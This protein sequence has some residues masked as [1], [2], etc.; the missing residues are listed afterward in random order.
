MKCPELRHELPCGWNQF[1]TF[2]VTSL[3]PKLLTWYWGRWRRFLST[4][5]PVPHKTMLAAARDWG[6]SILTQE[7]T[8]SVAWAEYVFE[9]YKDSPA[10]VLSF[11]LHGF[12]KTKTD[13]HAALNPTMQLFWWRKRLSKTW[14][15]L[16]TL[17]LCFLFTPQCYVQPRPIT[18]HV[19]EHEKWIAFQVLPLVKEKSSVSPK[20]NSFFREPTWA[21][22]PPWVSEPA[23]VVRSTYSLAPSLTGNPLFAGY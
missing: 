15:P 19:T 16:Q 5:D 11:K 12:E 9:D 21:N 14:I 20:E 4:G 3:F 8:R 1:A 23:L 17:P 22:P 6:E 2:H 10:W 7:A 13:F 18:L